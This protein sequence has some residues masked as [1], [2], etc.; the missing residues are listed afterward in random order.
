MVPGSSTLTQD[1]LFKAVQSEI[2]TCETTKVPVNPGITPTE[3]HRLDLIDNY[4]VSKFRDGEVDSLGNQMVFYNISSFPVE[5]ASKMLDF[6]TKDIALIA[7][8]ERYWETWLM[9]KELRMWMKENKFGKLLNELAFRLPRDGHVILKNIDGVVELVPLKN[10]RMRT[11]ALDISDTPI[12][13]K[14]E[15]AADEFVVEAQDRGWEN[16][17]KVELNPDKVT[18][19]YFNKVD[20]VT[21]FGAWFPKGFLDTDDNYFILSYDGHVLAHSEQELF[22][23]GIPWEELKG[24]LLGRGFVEKLFNEQIYLNRIANYKSDGLNWSSKHWFQTRDVSFKT[25]LL[26]ESDN[27]DVFVTNDPIEPVKVEDRNLSF[28]AQEE[29]R[30]EQQAMSRVFAT[31]PITGGRA[32]AGTPL[33]STILQARMA[34]GF[35]DQ[36][37]EEL[38]MLVKEI[39]WDWVMPEFKKDKKGQHSLMVKNIMTSDKGAEKFFNLQV[40]YRINKQKLGKFLPPEMWELKRALEVEKLK[41]SKIEIPKGFYDDLK[42]KM[43]I[44]IVGESIDTASKLTTLQTLFQIIGSNP[45]VMQNKTTKSILFKMLNLAGFNPKDFEDEDEPTVQEVSQQTQ[46]QRGGS[47]AAPVAPTTPQQVTEQQTI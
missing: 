44:D 38:A 20:K 15:Y 5:V 43:E 36:K 47:I 45:A 28:Y 9:E 46:A 2:D 4:M 7:Q 32:P 21:V 13:E 3:Q 31:E 19:G 23:K 17:E 18:T 35:F 24:R 33:G 42:L 39:I 1:E 16:W 34:T 12:I 14:F 8:D 22:Y 29:Q 27:G 40:N 37:K 10:L 30:W 25:N 11:T 6:D 26:G 41:N